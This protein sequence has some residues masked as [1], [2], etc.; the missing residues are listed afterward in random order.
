MQI[1]DNATIIYMAA[2]GSLSKRRIKV[3]AQTETHIRALCYARQQQ[4]TFKKESILGSQKS[5]A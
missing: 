2:D 4:R 3:L 1:G 5:Y